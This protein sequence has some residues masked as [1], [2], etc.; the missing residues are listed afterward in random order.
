MIVTIFTIALKNS[1]FSNSAQVELKFGQVQS[2]LLLSYAQV[3]EKISVEPWL[4]TRNT[5]FSVSVPQHH[6]QYYYSLMQKW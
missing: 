1:I 5:C 2:V 6:E 3:A 4:K